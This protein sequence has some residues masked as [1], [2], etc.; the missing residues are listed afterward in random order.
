MAADDRVD[1]FMALVVLPPPRLATL[2]L[3]HRRVLYF[4]TGCALERGEVAAVLGVTPKT[5]SNLI[6]QARRGVAA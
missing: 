5:V 2:T 3:R 6:S 4:T 1:L